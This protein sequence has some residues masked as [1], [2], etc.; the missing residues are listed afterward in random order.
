MFEKLVSIPGGLVTMETRKIPP[1][2]QQSANKSP[3]N[4]SIARPMP[5]YA[6]VGS[7]AIVGPI[8]PPGK[9]SFTMSSSSERPPKRVPS[10]VKTRP[11]TLPGIMFTRWLEASPPDGG[12]L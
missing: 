3:L 7:F 5:P 2:P 8:V 12:N 9:M 4:G 6:V 11:L 1:A 10:F